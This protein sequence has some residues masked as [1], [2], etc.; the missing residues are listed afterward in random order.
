MAKL[1]LTPPITP[2]KPRAAGGERLKDSGK[3]QAA[4]PTKVTLNLAMREKSPFTPT[5]LIPLLLIVLLAVSLFGKFA[6]A[7]RLARVNQAEAGLA[8]LQQQKA[9]L[10]ASTANYDSLVEEYSRYSVSWISDEE[11]ALVSRQE[12]IALIESELMSGGQVL[13]F[14]SNGNILSVELGGITL[15]GT[16]AIVQRLYQH[17]DVDTVSVYTASNENEAGN[18]ASVSMIITMKLPLEGGNQP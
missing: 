13:R 16:S 12:M 3:K 17:S 6:V 4:Y 2:G 1:K 10:E 14:S 11:K 9:T 15:N 5:K 8:T 18:Y 7:D